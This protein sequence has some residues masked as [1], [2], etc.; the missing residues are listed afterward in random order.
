MVHTEEEGDET[1]TEEGVH[2]VYQRYEDDRP[3]DGN[4]VGTKF[5]D[6]LQQ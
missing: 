2:V 4:G 3:V 5:I 1:E 6:K